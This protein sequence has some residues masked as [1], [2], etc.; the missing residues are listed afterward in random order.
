MGGVAAS[1]LGLWMFDLAV[2]QQM[3]VEC[4]FNSSVCTFIWLCLFISF[5][6]SYTWYA[7]S[8]SFTKQACSYHTH[9]TR[10]LQ[11]LKN[12]STH[13]SMRHTW[14]LLMIFFL[15]FWTISWLE[16]APLQL[17]EWAPSYCANRKILI[18]HY[19]FSCIYAFLWHVFWSVK[20]HLSLAFCAYELKSK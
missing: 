2:M 7:S 13:T 17:W 4:F 1:R 8:F 19:I 6:F 14:M 5:R 18:F 3:Q 12:C 16:P 10:T 15:I 20:L 9:V 11:F